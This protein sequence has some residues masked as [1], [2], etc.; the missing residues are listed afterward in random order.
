MNR[1]KLKFSILIELGNFED[2]D[3]S[4]LVVSEFSVFSPIT[5]WRSAGLV[6]YGASSILRSCSEYDFVQNESQFETDIH[7]FLWFI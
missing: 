5:S 4:L 2:V 3:G 6:P 7:S 1:V